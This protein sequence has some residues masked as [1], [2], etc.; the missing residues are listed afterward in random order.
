MKINVEKLTK[1]FGKRMILN[2]VDLSL[3]NGIY[4]L[5]G[6]NGAGKTTL[7]HCLV[8]LYSFMGKIECHDPDVIHHSTDF[9]SLVGYLPQYPSFY[10]NY[11]AYEFLDYMCSLKGIL[12]DSRLEIIN[13]L[14]S[15]VNLLDVSHKKI[16]EYSGGMKQRLGIAQALLNDPKLLI[17]DEPTAGL[18]PKE[19]MRF[20]NILLQLSKDRIVI[21]STHII[22]DIEDIADE[23][24]FIKNGCIL[25]KDTIPNLLS[26]INGE[27]RQKIISKQDMMVED[28]LN[29]IKMKNEGDS[30]KIRFFGS[31]GDY[32]KPNLD[33]LYM[34]YFGDEYD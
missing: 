19:R 1:H 21:F 10:K 34:K 28:K 24:I 8:G 32:V 23:I 30:Y 20:K 18:D 33:D 16:G 4:A 26:Q 31:D 27:V 5:I 6:P 7:I 3:E 13:R 14:L 25:Q 2:Q 17:L 15:L 9:L 12:K 22:S 11:S 29:I